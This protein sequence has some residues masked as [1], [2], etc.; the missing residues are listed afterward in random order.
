MLARIK[1][2]RHDLLALGIIVAALSL[3]HLRGILPGQTFLPV[4]LANNL[5]PWRSGD[6]QPLQNPLITD[7]LFEFYPYLVFSLDTFKTTGQW[8]LW[9]PDI[10]LGHPALADPNYQ[11]FYPV[12]L[13]L[14]L[15]LG[16][17]RAL[18]IGPWLHALVAGFLVYA[19][20][21]T[22]G[23]SRRAAL[24]AALAYAAGGQMVTWFGARQWLGTLTWLPGVLWA[25][26]LLLARGRWRYLA[27][28]MAFQGVALLSGQYQVWLAFSLFLLA[29]AGLRTLE[30]RRAGRRLSGRP[31][32]AAA[33]IVA[34]G[35]LLAAIQ[36]LPSIEY[37]AMS[38]RTDALLSD[39][40]MD[41][42]QLISLVIPDF[43]GNPATVGDYWGQLNYSERTIYSGLVVLLL[44][45]LA[46]LTVRRRRFLAIG[47]SLLA[48]MVVYFVVG[49]PGIELLQAVPGF[50]YLALAR[51]TFLLS[52]LAALLAAMTLDEPPTS[53][54]PPVLAAL[55][56]GGLAALAVG[57]NWGGAQEHW[58]DLREPLLRSIV[59]L[60]IATAL[61]V[62]RAMNAKTR[63]W[64]EW[65]LIGL[66]FLDLY[67]WGHGF[68]PAGPI[69]EL[70]PP[71]AAT[72][73]VQANA[74]EQRV[75]PLMPGW[76]LAFGPN[77]LSTFGV[78][79]PG[80]Y[81]SLA[82]A[83]LRELFVAGDPQGRHWNILA[84]EQPALRLLDLF[85]VGLVASPRPLDAV[86]VQMEVG[87][88]AC[89][90]SSEEITATTPVSGRF[91]PTESAINRFDLKF[92]RLGG[93][94]GA[95][96]LQVRLW[97]GEER[98][99]LVLEAQQATAELADEQ[100]V[101][102]YFAPESTAP[103]QTYVWE[104][105]ATNGAATG[106]SLCLAAD[107]QPAQAVYGQVWTN[108]F[109]DGIYY[110]QRS[111]PMAR[112]YVVY[113]AETVAGDP[114]AVERLL[115]PAFD[116]RNTALVAE[117]LDLPATAPQP[118]SRATLVEHRQT[119]V[120]VDATAAQPGLLILGD[121]W[122]PGWRVTVDGQPAELLR[123]NHVLRGVLLPAGQHRVEFRFQPSSLRNGGLLSLAALLALLALLVLDRR[124]RR[125][126]NT[127]DK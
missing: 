45:I 124:Q 35:A 29:Y 10:F 3:L 26:E 8:P 81:S 75:A 30:E 115:S 59:L 32:V 80:G 54:W 108:V 47:L 58:D 20:I 113:A 118:A 89:A 12:Y 70:L 100:E 114:Q 98:E 28:A 40:A 16:A 55:L 18:A 117:P 82:P 120:V 60:A 107:G 13:A 65:V 11:T 52:L 14:G 122:H 102:W 104:V 56:L 127:L 64:S 46:P 76:D 106:A 17:A 92:R 103:G 86:D 21:R 112:A 93:A 90:G 97:Q 96:A 34:V 126:E 50:K 2:A 99:R 38:H 49:G 6:L 88:L 94:D 27:L 84:F 121:L 7:P 39:T 95:A 24:L 109:D 51:S 36:L 23:Y 66:V 53:P 79:E 22:M 72:E 111:A 9:N 69:D 87:P 73:F 41:P 78:A 71:N 4:D 62:V 85:Q 44:A 61:L 57:A 25:F 74:G 119:K 110:Q 91:V 68:N 1:R 63:R 31:L 33:A 43:F 125:A 15:A 19:W 37:L 123:A 77:I 101:T 83:R 105:S 116:L 67:G 5:Y 48:V 42:V